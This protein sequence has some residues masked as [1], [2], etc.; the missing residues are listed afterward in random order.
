MGAGTD[1]VQFI[2]SYLIDEQPVRGNV[3]FPISRI[4]PSQIV[5]LILFWEWGGNT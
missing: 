4:I 5:V 2:S 3:T 1:K